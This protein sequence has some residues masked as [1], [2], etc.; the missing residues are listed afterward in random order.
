[1]T[2]SLPV[3]LAFGRQVLKKF[4]IYSGQMRYSHARNA[5]IQPNQLFLDIPDRSLYDLNPIDD[6]YVGFDLEEEK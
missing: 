5:E 3:F 6:P 4:G 2:L 1:M